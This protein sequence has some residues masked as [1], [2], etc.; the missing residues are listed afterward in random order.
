[1]IVRAVHDAD[2]FQQRDGYCAVVV[3][4]QFTCNTG[5]EFNLR[6]R[7]DMLACLTTALA[8]PITAIKAPKPSTWWPLAAIPPV[9]T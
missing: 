6:N 7:I 2:C 3:T 1:M 4:P 8:G 5:F 9:S